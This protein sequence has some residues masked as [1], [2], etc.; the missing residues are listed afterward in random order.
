M[1][2][3]VPDDSQTAGAQSSRSRT[4]A[5]QLGAHVGRAGTYG[6]QRVGATPITLPPLSLI[7]RAIDGKPSQLGLDRTFELRPSSQSRVD[8]PTCRVVEVLAGRR[9]DVPECREHAGDDPCL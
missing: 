6:V 2:T 3:Y 5:L 4:V 8:L 1:R 9:S 7:S